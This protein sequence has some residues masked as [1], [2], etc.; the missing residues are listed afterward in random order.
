MLHWWQQH[1]VLQSPAARRL[2]DAEA[3]S[4]ATKWICITWN[5][6]KNLFSFAPNKIPLNNITISIAH[7]FERLQPTYRFRLE[8]EPLLWSRCQ[9]THHVLLLV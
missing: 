9:T 3:C 1:L 6:T 7:I 8:E 2:T 4:P 5:F